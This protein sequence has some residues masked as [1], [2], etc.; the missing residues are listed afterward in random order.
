ML[1]SSPSA[2]L[3][4]AETISSGKTRAETTTSREQQTA[5]RLYL[6]EL[7][8]ALSSEALPMLREGINMAL[9]RWSAL[10][11]AVENEWGSRNS[12]DIANKLCDDVFVWF[13]HSKEPLY[14]EDLD[15]KLDQGLLSLNTE[16]DDG[17]IGEVAEKLM[18]LHEE[19][20]EGNYSSIEKLRE[21]CAHRMVH[22]HVKQA[23]ERSSQEWWWTR[24]LSS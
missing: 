11:M 13:T 10:Q 12:R 15:E 5:D 18:I 22:Y 24:L 19:C 6:M 4:G 9:S 23:P 14:I 20:S 2:M 7:P 8:K 17:S 3:G 1:R 16:T 21:A